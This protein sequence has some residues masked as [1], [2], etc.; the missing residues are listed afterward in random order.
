MKVEPCPKCGKKDLDIGDCGYSSFNVA[1][2][3]CKKCKLKHSVT[4]DSAVKG[5]NKWARKPVAM[6]IK[7]IR[8]NAKEKHRRSY[9]PNSKKKMNEYV[10]MQEYAADLIEDH[11]KG[12]S[13]G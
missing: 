8:E 1:W 2:V 3:Q 10:T 5:W 4:G 9:P 12:C 7:T 11:E 13:C 6:L